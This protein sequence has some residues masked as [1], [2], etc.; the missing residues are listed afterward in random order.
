MLSAVK[1]LQSLLLMSFAVM[2]HAAAPD[3]QARDTAGNVHNVNEY[4]GKGKWTVV[5]FW[6]HDCHIC[7]QEIQQ[8][9]FFQDGH[10]EKDAT[11]LGISMDGFD[12]VAKSKA[13]IERHELNFPNLLITANQREFLK[14]GGG[15]Y[16]GTPTFYIYNPAG[17]LLAKNI[18]P[19]SP[20]EIEAF[21]KSN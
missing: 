21:I 13:F 7:N 6:A 1:I 4:I 10:A 8:M 11:V 19:V 3:V 16:V 17:T 14:F 20:E 5:V 2:A 15:G 9:T 18:G 12:R